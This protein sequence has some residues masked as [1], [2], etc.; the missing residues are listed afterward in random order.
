MRA[1]DPVYE[2]LMQWNMKLW[3]ER[4]TI[5]LGKKRK[6]I[7]KPWWL[8]LTLDYQGCRASSKHRE[9]FK[10]M[11]KEPTCR[12]AILQDN[13]GKVNC[14]GGKDCWWVWS[15]CK[16]YLLPGLGQKGRRLLPWQGLGNRCQVALSSHRITE[17]QN[18]RGWKRPLW[19][20]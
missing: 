6:G 19:V 4:D 14:K 11:G 20:I 3:F 2:G 18:G 13:S 7:E 15:G 10:H 17:S 8:L 16:L 12:I 5:K 1:M 9:A